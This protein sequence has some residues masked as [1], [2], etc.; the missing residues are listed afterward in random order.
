MVEDFV[1]VGVVDVVVE[2]V[3][4][5]YLGF[6]WVGDGDEVFEDGW[7]VGFDLFVGVLEV[8][9]FFVVGVVFVLE[10]LMGY[11]YVVDY[12]GVKVVLLVGGDVVFG[13][14]GW[15]GMRDG[16]RESEVKWSGGW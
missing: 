5:G 8:E 13:Y 3:V 2:V 12:V 16:M 10:M 9:E 7:G 15:E 4:F 6:G 1:G 11:D 14:F